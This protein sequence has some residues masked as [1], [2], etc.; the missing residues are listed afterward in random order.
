MSS[1]RHRNNGK[2]P[3]GVDTPG[4]V[5]IEESRRI[6]LLHFGIEGM[7]RH[8]ILKHKGR[9]DSMPCLSSKLVQGQEVHITPETINSIYWKDLTHPA[10]G[11]KR[12]FA[13]K[14][15]QYAWVASIIVEG[16]PQWAV[17]KGDIHRHD[18]KFE[19]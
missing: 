8:D 7:A 3:M 17:M 13:D 6:S 15:S 12:R 5:D 11:F 14:G 1:S 9:V 19:A 10:L 18:L 16:Q 4:E 2:A